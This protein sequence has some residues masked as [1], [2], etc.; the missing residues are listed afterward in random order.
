[1]DMAHKI[2]SPLHRVFVAAIR[3]RRLELSL[4]QD[5]VARLMGVSQSAYAHIEGGRCNPTIDVVER[6]AKALRANPLQLLVTQE[7]IAS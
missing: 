6:V 1:M 5:D 2:D 7:L 3:A 4:T